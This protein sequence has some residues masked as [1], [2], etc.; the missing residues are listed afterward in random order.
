MGHKIDQQVKVLAAKS[1]DLSYIPRTCFL[2]GG[3]QFLKAVLWSPQARGV[4][5]THMHTIKK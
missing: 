5:C 4:M 3:K 2:E 1:D